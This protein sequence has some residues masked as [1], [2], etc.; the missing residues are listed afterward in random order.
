M[1]KILG[2]FLGLIALVIVGAI[3][4][5][6]LSGNGTA[7]SDGNILTSAAND[8]KVAA[9]NA[10]I[11]ASGIKT[12]VKDAIDARKGDIAAATGLTTD[13][14][15]AAVGSLDIDSWQAASLPSGATATATTSGSYAGVDGTI[16]TY[17]D[18]GYVTVEAYG[19]EVT[20]SVPESAQQYLPFLNYL[21]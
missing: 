9:T 10:A 18:P 7:N 13:Q 2:A 5:F 4:V 6:A 16:T 8:A 14:V 3:G 17:D 11:D 19:Q 20:L 1:K 12:K 21:G 15:D